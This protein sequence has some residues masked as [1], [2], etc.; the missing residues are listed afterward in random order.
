MVDR[1]PALSRL[2]EH[3][4]V[5][6]SDVW[7]VLHNGVAAYPTPK[8]ALKT[9]RAAGVKVILL[10]NSPRLG[11]A[12]AEQL[13]A[14]GV[15]DESYDAIVTSGDVTRKLVIEGPRSL[16]HIGPPRD[17]S[18]TDGT[19]VALVDEAT[20]EGILCTGLF[21]DES[22]TAEDYRDMLERFV[23]RGVPLICANP[24]LVVSRGDRLVPCAGALAALYEELGGETL[25][26]G[27]PHTPIYE[28]ALAKA[29]GLLGDVEKTRV[30]AIGDGMPTDVR[31]AMDYG[32]DL[33]YIAEGIH[34]ADY[35]VNGIVDEAS[36][37][38]FL[39]EKGA[40]PKYWMPELA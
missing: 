8:E 6:L 2:H 5:M 37:L 27:K 38:R 17:T 18:L 10:T 9:A 19:E 14:L 23:A 4:D 30:L 1:I 16:F 21:D 35:T 13:A 32:L 20:A 36:L 15:T 3:Y 26:A 25:I 12:V 29:R 34:A 7:G 22:E 39:T 11:P 33:L 40:S 24:D 31:G 28:A